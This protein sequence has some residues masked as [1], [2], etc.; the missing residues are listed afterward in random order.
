MDPQQYRGFLNDPVLLLNRTENANVRQIRLHS[1]MASASP[2]AVFRTVQHPGAVRLR[3][4]S[5]AARAVP[6]TLRYDDTGIPATSAVWVSRNPPAGEPFQRDRAYYLHWASD[7]AHAVELGSDAQLFF[8]AELT[9]C[10]ILIFRAP[11][12]TI[13]VHHNIQVDPVPPTLFQ[14]LFESAAARN[15][16]AS[17]HSGEVKENAL[18]NLAQH[19]IAATPGITGGTQLSVRQYGDK[20]RVFGIKRGGQWRLFVNRPVGG[21]YRTELLHG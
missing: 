6:V 20:A 18:H 14:R 4:Q 2:S 21:S 15:E 17:M 9:G 3:Y 13:V 10:G 11:G 8:T 1:S 7:E 12:T 19:I 16:R 5:S